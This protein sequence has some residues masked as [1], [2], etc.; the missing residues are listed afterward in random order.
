MNKIKGDKKGDKEVKKILGNFLKGLFVGGTLTVPGVSGGSMAIILNVYD[1]LLSSVNS[2][3]KK[4][5]KRKNALI[6]LLLFGGGGVLGVLAFSGIVSFLMEK[7]PLYTCFFFVGAVVG[8]APVVFKKAGVRRFTFVDILMIFIGILLVRAVAL[9]PDGLFS[10]DGMGGVGGILLKALCGV[11]LAFGL[12]LPGISFS[13]LLYVFGIYEDVFDHIARFDI[14]PLI[15]IGIGGVAGIFAT[16]YGVECLMKRY[17]KRVYL[18][19]FGFLL[20]SV[21]T[22]FKGQSFG[23]S[24]I[25]SWFIFAVLS[26]IGFALVYL[27]SLEEM[28]REA[29]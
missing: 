16:S 15:P 20:G 29:N 6:F 24:G 14:L 27:M 4:G 28:K 17:P 13:Q 3:F 2:I 5:E 25:L 23:G 11:V 19:V 7:F 10:I 9:I 18:I 12:V 1:T 21:P 8:G 22:M 26:V